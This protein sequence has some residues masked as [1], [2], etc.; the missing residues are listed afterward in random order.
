MWKRLIALAL[1]TLTL[2]SL[3]VGCGTGGIKEDPYVQ[4][5]FD[6]SEKITISWMI[7]TQQGLALSETP[8]FKA[9]EEKL[10]IEIELIEMPV[11]QFEEKKKL[12]IASKDLPDMMS[13]TKGSEAN[14]YGPLG[15]FVELSRYLEYM[16]SLQEKINTAISE[17][18]NV[19]YAVYNADNKMYMTPHYLVDPIPIF[20]FSYVK[21]EF[22]ALG[23]T[24]L[25]TWDDVYNALKAWKAQNPDQYP[26]GFRN[27]GTLKETL[28]LF[29]ESFTGARATTLDYTGYDYDI[30]QFVFALD[31]DG[32][33][34]AV[35][36]FAK[37]YTEGLV[38]PDY[39][40][41]D[42]QM[43]KTRIKRGKIVMIADYIGGWTGIPSIMR[44]VDHKL[45]PLATPKAEGQDVVIGREIPVFDSSVG[46]VLNHNITSD[47]VKLGRCLLFLD[48]LYS[49]EFFEIQW[50]NPDV[51][52]QNA[53]GSYTY[54]DVVYDLEGDYGLMKDTYFPWSMAA[55]FQDAME[56]RPTIGSPYQIYR[57]TYLRGEESK[58]KYK[59]FPVVPL[60]L[61]EQQAVNKAV[62]SITDRF[63][64]AISEFVEGKRSMDEWDEFSESLKKAGGDELIRI[65]NE[66]LKRMTE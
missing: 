23:Y 15:A 51:T 43:L 48:Y 32:Y 8:M 42:E 10:N 13:W 63:N 45:Y 54:K 47:P 56:E 37:L 46:T 19:R 55:N 28:R 18:E 24:E 61:E 52:V 33:K 35:A 66:A 39:T 41:M 36:Y 4:P 6:L 17:S 49:S 21:S 34:D 31:V 26:L 12:N 38:H 1:A 40:I 44:D 62:A 2:C 30:N 22:D 25:N 65:Y 59:P 14:E 29:V 60:T 58:D 9:I 5:N 16:P 7:P 64:A 50:H 3:F 11:A 27:H 57:D 20:D 53:D